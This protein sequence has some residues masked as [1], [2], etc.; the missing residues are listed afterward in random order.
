MITG[1]DLIQ[2]GTFE[3]LYEANKNFKLS[4]RLEKLVVKTSAQCFSLMSK[5]LEESIEKRISIK[6]ALA[7]PWFSLEEKT[8]IKE[9]HD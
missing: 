9:C 3:T 6:Q 5:L 4:V 1:E 8:I 2:Q 7:D